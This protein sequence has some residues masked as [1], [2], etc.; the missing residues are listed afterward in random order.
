MSQKKRVRGEAYT[1]EGYGTLRYELFVASREHII[2]SINEGY[3][4]E[5]TAVIESII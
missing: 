3:Y 2:R 1:G 4:L 5:A